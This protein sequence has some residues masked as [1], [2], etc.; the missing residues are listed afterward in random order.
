MEELIQ[1]KEM[2]MGR[3][4]DFGDPEKCLGVLRRFGSPEYIRSSGLVSH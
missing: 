2:E 3:S 4:N 1:L